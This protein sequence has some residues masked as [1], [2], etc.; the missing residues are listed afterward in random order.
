MPHQTEL[1]EINDLSHG[2]RRLS[3]IGSTPGAGVS[4]GC[5]ACQV[6]QQAAEEN[7]QKRHGRVDEHPFL[8]AFTG[9]WNTAQVV[10]YYDWL[11]L[12]E[13]RRMLSSLHAA[14][15]RPRMEGSA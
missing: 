13:S 3:S 7:C 14:Q 5:I 4:W 6:E 2:A 10:A 15:S 11:L 12:G 1:T 9:Q 8:I